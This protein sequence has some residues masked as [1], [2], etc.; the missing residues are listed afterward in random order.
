MRAWATAVLLILAPVS[1]SEARQT[2]APLRDALV[3]ALTPALPYPEA[4]DDG[5]PKGG[6]TAPAWTVRWPDDDRAIVEVVANPLNAENHARALKAESAIQ[7][8]AMQS[9]QRSQAD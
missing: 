5:T 7:K 6:D 2:G 1:A 9:Q 8:A 4:T 3:A